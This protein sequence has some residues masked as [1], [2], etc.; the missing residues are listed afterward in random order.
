MPI[1]KT[2]SSLV[3]YQVLEQLKLSNLKLQVVEFEADE[4]FL[5]NNNGTVIRVSRL[6]SDAGEIVVEQGPE[7]VKALVSAQQVQVFNELFKIQ[8]V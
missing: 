4:V 7:E 8:T 2:V 3:A 6:S 1:V 5:T